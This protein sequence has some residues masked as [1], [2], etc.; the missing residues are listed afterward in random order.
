MEIIYSDDAKKD[1]AY[2][3]K[4][5]TLSDKNKIKAL[6]QSIKETP[7]YGIGKPE[8]LKYELSGYWSRR[9]DKENRIIYRVKL[10]CIEIVSF[11]GHY[12]SK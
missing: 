2:W 7:F 1:L 3:D 5:G 4:Y 6:L 11:K 10:N 9:I 12:E 8:A